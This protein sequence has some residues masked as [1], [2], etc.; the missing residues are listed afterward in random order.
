M[1]T[2]ENSSSTGP[3]RPRCRPNAS[4]SA[5][6]T[7][8]PA[9]S[10]GRSTWNNGS[11]TTRPRSPWPTRSLASRG[12]SGT[13][14]EHSTATSPPPDTFLFIGCAERTTVTTNRNVLQETKSTPKCRSTLERAQ[15]VPKGR[16]AWTRHATNSCSQARCTVWLPLCG[17]HDGQ[18]PQPSSNRTAIRLQPPASHELNRSA[19]AGGVHIRFVSRHMCTVYRDFRPAGAIGQTTFEDQRP[20]HCQCESPQE[21]GPD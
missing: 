19:L 11:A 8:S 6:P 4:P 3:G 10:A 5:N 17:L 20:V 14:T 9:C 13:T 18:M 7:H 12:P 1:S 16:G 21:R 2:S 15:R